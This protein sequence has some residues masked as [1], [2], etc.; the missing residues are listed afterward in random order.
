MLLWP[1]RQNKFDKFEKFK[2]NVYLMVESTWI[3]GFGVIK[4]RVKNKQK[5]RKYQ[6]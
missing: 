4:I 3:F 6:K 5:V 2:K 1:Q